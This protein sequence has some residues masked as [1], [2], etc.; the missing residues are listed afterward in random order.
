MGADIGKKRGT[1]EKFAKK[2]VK[3]VSKVMEI[4]RNLLQNGGKL[5]R[6]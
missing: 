6:I 4:L 5:G 2:S 3:K 1:D